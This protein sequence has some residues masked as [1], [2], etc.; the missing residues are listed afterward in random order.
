LSHD[1]AVALLTYDTECFR[2]SPNRLRAL[3]QAVVFQQGH[4]ARR[5]HS[6]CRPYLWRY[7]STHVVRACKAR[8]FD[9]VLTEKES[10][11]SGTADAND[12]AHRALYPR[13]FRSKFVVACYHKFDVAAKSN[14]HD[15]ARSDRYNLEWHAFFECLG[16]TPPPIFGESKAS[17]PAQ[18]REAAL[19]CV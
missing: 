18:R 8:P 4:C 19:T 6:E 5:E 1:P 7:T 2:A 17:G 10:R 9:R 14:P 11:S 12:L 16:N 15:T 13:R 3:V